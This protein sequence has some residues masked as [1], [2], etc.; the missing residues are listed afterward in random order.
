MATNSIGPGTTNLSVNIPKSLRADIAK[1]AEN[2]GMKNASE[3][4]RALLK[5]ARDKKLRMV[6]NQYEV[7]EV[8]Q[9]TDLI[10]AEDPTDYKSMLPPPTVGEIKKNRKKKTS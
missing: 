10:A 1:L 7:I 4:V 9:E 2:S 8:Y 6:K 3:Y 5:Y